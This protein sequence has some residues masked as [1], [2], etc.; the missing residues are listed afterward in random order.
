MITHN[1]RFRACGLLLNRLG[2]LPINLVLA[3]RAPSDG[4]ASLIALLYFPLFIIRS[5]AGLYPVGTPFSACAQTVL[6]ELVRDLET[7]T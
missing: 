4:A 6:T 5:L 2:S 1:Q 3:L 7:L